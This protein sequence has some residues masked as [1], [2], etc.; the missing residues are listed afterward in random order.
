MRWTLGK[1]GV[2]SCCATPVAQC[3]T[4]GAASN[5]A[6]LTYWVKPRGGARHECLVGCAV[7]PGRVLRQ[8]ITGRLIFGAPSPPSALPQC[9]AVG[10]VLWWNRLLGGVSSFLSG[11]LRLGPSLFQ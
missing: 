9:G 4:P 3:A 7:D 8:N 2:R 5:L 6:A 1:R 10:G 11:K